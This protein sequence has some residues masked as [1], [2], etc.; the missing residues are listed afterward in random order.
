LT[1]IELVS[2]PRD[3]QNQRGCE[4]VDEVVP[5]GPV[6]VVIGGHGYCPPVASRHA[7]YAPTNAVTQGISEISRIG[8]QCPENRT[9]V[10]HVVSVS[11]NRDEATDVVALKVFETARQ[12]GQ[13]VTIGLARDVIAEL[14]SHPSGCCQACTLAGRVKPERCTWLPPK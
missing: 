2:F 3:P 1:T 14:A 7:A 11:V 12:R 6:I 13:P 10:F 4:L 5:I 8:T 9:K